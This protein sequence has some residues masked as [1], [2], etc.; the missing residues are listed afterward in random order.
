MSLMKITILGSGTSCGI[1]MIGCECEVCR[2]NNPKNKR[3]RSAAYV[4]TAEGAFLIDVG[5]DF[6]Q[7]ALK[8][9][10]KRVDAL[11]ITHA[12]ADHIAGLDDLRIF[13]FIQGGSIKIFGLPHILKEIRERFDYCFNPPQIGGGVPQL[14]LIPVEESFTLNGTNITP[15]PVMHGR[16]PI[17]GWRFDD[18]SYVTD[19]SVIPKES[20]KKLE[21]TQVLVLNALRHNPHSTHISLSEAVEYARKIKP[22]MTYFTHISHQLEHWSTNRAL[23]PNARLA[24]DGMV[25]DIKKE[26]GVETASDRAMH[27]A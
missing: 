8:H 19:A 10:I 25:I 23:P 7:Q 24:Y 21:G 22:E 1:P 15:I 2:S 26:G 16:L 27:N 18:F 11:F 12:H 14:E 3:L 6:R 13:N 9:D 17:T 5:P 4:Q 20:M